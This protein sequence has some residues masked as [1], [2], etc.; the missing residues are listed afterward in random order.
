MGSLEKLVV[1]MWRLDE[2]HALAAPALPGD[3]AD[4]LHLLEPISDER[5]GGWKWLPLAAILGVWWWRQQRRVAPKPRPVTPIEVP[6]R[7]PL[8]SELADKI[9]RLRQQVLLTRRYREGCHRL[10]ALLRQR[11]EEAESQPMTVWT[12]GE[13][14]AYLGDIPLSRA[15][16]LLAELQFGRRA[17]GRDDFE[18]ACELAA[19]ASQ[20][21]RW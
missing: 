8:G 9:E 7:L 10:A 20:G 15:M 6:K 4:V 18:G 16:A 13:I 21:R 2:S 11:G 3:L 1:E 12:Q 17:P 19:E 14:T 5:W